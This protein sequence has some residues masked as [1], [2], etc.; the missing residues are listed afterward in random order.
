MAGLVFDGL[1]TAKH[2]ELRSSEGPDLHRNANDSD[3]LV[4]DVFEE[5]MDPGVLPAGCAVDVRC[6]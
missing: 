4:L 1:R 2:G 6:P 5:S 3:P